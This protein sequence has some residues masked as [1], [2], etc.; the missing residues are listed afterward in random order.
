MRNDNNL[1]DDLHEDILH[2]M[3]FHS[4]DA[5]IMIAETGG[6]AT[7]EDAVKSI[8][9]HVTDL[10]GFVFHSRSR[11][12]EANALLSRYQTVLE[13]YQERELKVG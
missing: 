8:Q 1:N 13:K 2:V 9:E 3:N 7:R 12:R 4:A 6:H 5:G 11:M 10:E